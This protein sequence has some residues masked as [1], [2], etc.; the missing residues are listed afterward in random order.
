MSDILFGKN[1][2]ETDARAEEK[3]TPSFGR[4]DV[5]SS[6]VVVVV[7]QKEYTRAPLA[8]KKY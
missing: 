4:T 8:K 7:V 1:N 3:K 2:S 5:K 6:S